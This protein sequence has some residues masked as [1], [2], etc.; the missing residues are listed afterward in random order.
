MENDSSGS[1]PRT[2]S[3]ACGFHTSWTHLSS[4]TNP[5][6]QVVERVAGWSSGP[7]TP[8]QGLWISELRNARYEANDSYVHVYCLYIMCT[9][10]E[11]TDHH[12]PAKSDQ[13]WM[14]LCVVDGRGRKTQPTISPVP[15][16]GE[17]SCWLVHAVGTCGVSVSLGGRG[18]QA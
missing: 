15:F 7:N 17:Q 10:C 5:Y 13:G 12:S 4:R 14:R 11:R 16:S 2:P 1:I 3:C 18:G 8:G 6:V 9:V